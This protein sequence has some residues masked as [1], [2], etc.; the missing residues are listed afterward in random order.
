[1]KNSYIRIETI[2]HGQSHPYGDH[3]Y[4]KEL[5]FQV[6]DWHVPPRKDKPIVPDYVSRE[7][8]LTIARLYCPYDYDDVLNPDPWARYLVSFERLEPTPYIIGEGTSRAEVL[9]PAPERSDRW[10]IHVRERFT[11]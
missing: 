9:V 3:D 1:M 2:Q 4:I 5:T 8:A 11:D 10:R 6:D 7:K